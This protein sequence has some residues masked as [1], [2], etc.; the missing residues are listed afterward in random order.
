LS[1]TTKKQ[2]KVVLYCIEKLCQ[3]YPA[4]IPIL[5]SFLN[6][7]YIEEVLDEDILIQWYKHPINDP[8]R[9]DPKVSKS[10]REA[11]KPFID[12]LQNT[13]TKNSDE[14]F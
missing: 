12:W 9:F 8:K 5:H 13:E 10:I 6:G 2:Q 14:D 7:F 4:T 1:K 11:A 3:L